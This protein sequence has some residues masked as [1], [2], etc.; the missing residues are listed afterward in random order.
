MTAMSI[1]IPVSYDIGM[2]LA[3]A[4]IAISATFV[5]FGYEILVKE[6]DWSLLRRLIQRIL[7][8]QPFRFS[9]GSDSDDGLP[10][11]ASAESPNADTGSTPASGSRPG[12]TRRRTLSGV[13]GNLP[14]HTQEIPG[15]ISV[16]AAFAENTAR[17]AEGRTPARLTGMS[18]GDMSD[19]ASASTSSTSLPAGSSSDTFSGYSDLS[20]DGYL[21]HQEAEMERRAREEL[22]DGLWGGKTIVGRF[23]WSLWF[24]LTSRVLT[25]GVLLGSTVCAM[26]FSGML[27]MRMQGFIEWDYRLVA[28]SVLIAWGACI[29]AIVYSKPSTLR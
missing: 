13:A 15:T 16:A 29:V 14:D 2:T 18:S 1:G 23:M 11:L 8:S 28:C 20:R 6:L 9:H 5:T 3:S 4:A 26:H 25:K 19:V 12:L 21:G 27:S 24:S 10:L 22:L 7:P 17:V